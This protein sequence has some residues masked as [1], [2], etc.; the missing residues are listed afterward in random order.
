MKEAFRE[1][2]NR[3][4]G[5]QIPWDD[6]QLKGS[7]LIILPWAAGALLPPDL[8]SPES[9]SSTFPDLRLA[10]AVSAPGS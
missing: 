9:P 5:L 3:D 1:K 7:V 6:V 8:P 10:L 4:L 2:E